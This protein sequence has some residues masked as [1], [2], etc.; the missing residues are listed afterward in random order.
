LRWTLGQLSQITPEL[1]ERAKALGLGLGA[2][3]QPYHGARPRGP[4]GGPPWRTL[5]E[6]NP[7]ALAAGSDGTRINSIN[8]WCIIY[9]MVTGRNVSGDLVNDGQQISRYD[10]V[11]LYSSADQGWFTGEDDLL[12]GIGVGRYA[13]LAI[14]EADI[15]DSDAVPDAVIR[16]MKSVL[17]IVNG[18]IVFDS[19]AIH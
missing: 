15:F 16:N 4:Q 12:G 18:E 14:L 3:G 8:P 5:L 13:D 17:T 10:A 11:R 7:V 19:G 1:I 6:S 2:H 9:Y